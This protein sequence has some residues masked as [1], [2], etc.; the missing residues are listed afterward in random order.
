[1]LVKKNLLNPNSVS[2]TPGGLLAKLWRQFL[3]HPF[4]KGKD[5]GLYNNLGSRL[6]EVRERHNANTIED[7]VY[8]KSLTHGAFFTLLTTFM[9]GNK[10]YVTIELKHRDYIREVLDIEEYTAHSVVYTDS[11]DRPLGKEKDN[12]TRLMDRINKD[13]HLLEKKNELAN[14]IGKRMQLEEDL[15]D[16]EVSAY[17]SKLK[18]FLVAKKLSWNDFIS[19]LYKMLMVEMYRIVVTVEFTKLRLSMTESI[20]IKVDGKGEWNSGSDREDR[21][22]NG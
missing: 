7:W 2:F 21:T 9:G 18:R 17:K 3:V 13:L 16:K 11:I 1:M 6:R 20:L 14:V 19:V 15:T 12:I 22:D 5:D 10:V 4:T 8:A